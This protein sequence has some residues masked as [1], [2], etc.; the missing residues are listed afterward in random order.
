MRRS[1]SLTLFLAILAVVSGFMLSSASWIG[2]IGVSLFHSEYEFLRDWW[3]GA[4]LVFTVWIFLYAVQSLILKISSHTV[5]NIVNIFAVV[6]AIIGLYFTYHD[7]RHNLSHRWMG[8]RFH[9][10]AYLFWIGWIIISA[11]LLMWAKNIRAM[12]RKVGMDV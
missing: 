8:E 2:N 10:G 3:K 11:Y 4:I 5:S 6:A 9:I 7:F 12:K 1:A